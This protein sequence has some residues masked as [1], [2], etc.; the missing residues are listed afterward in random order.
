[1]TVVPFSFIGVVLGLWILDLPFTIMT[2]IAIVGLSGVVVND[3]I[4]LVEF[5]TEARRRGESMHDAVLAGV[6]TRLR[7]IFLTTL[8]TV[9]GLLPTALGLTGKSKIWS[10]FAATISFGL[11]LAMFLTLFLV[12]AVFV[13]SD[14]IRNRFARKSA[15]AA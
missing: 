7:P 13:F 14:R 10:P 4:V 12:P 6:R 15:S 9:L 2:F 11:L 8:T 1:M 3:S 5:I